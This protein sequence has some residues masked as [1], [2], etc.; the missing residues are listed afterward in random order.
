MALAHS[1]RIVTDG[2]VLALD[3]SNP[4]SYPGSGTTWSDLIGSNNGTLTNGPTF[5]SADGGSIVFDGTNDYSS[6]SGSS[7]L[8][9]GAG[10]FTVEMW[11]YATNFTNRGTFFDG[12]KS[13]ALLGMVIGHES[14][15]GEIRVYMNP[16][17]LVVST[18]DFSAGLWNHIAVT[19]ESTTVRLFVNGSLKAT[20]TGANLSDTLSP[21]NIGYRTYTSSSYTYFNGKISNVKI[22]KAKGLTASEVQQNYNALKGRFGI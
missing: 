21:V 16:P 22:Y 5:S 17:T 20:G 2:L 11:V 1:P 8:T 18:T 19:C 12:R 7:D 4:R 15:T 10:D 3:A 6:I 9:F 13:D 14:S